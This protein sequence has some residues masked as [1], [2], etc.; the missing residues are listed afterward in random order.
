MPRAGDNCARRTLPASA[1][2]FDNLYPTNHFH[3]GYM[4]LMAWKNMVNYA[5]VFDVK[6]DPVS[7]VQVNFIIHRLANSKDNWYRAGQVVYGSVRCRTTRPP[8]S[9]R[10]STSTI[11]GRSKRS[12]SLK[13]AMATSL[14]G[15]T[16]TTRPPMG[17]PC[18]VP[19]PVTTD[20]NWG[21]VMGSVLF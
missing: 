16:S 19:L 12:S 21:Y 10:R 11:S 5:V 2:T 20:Q 18:R 9:G 15:I 14:P 4:D 17:T 13:S 1:N 3:Y 7:K 8:L 6:P